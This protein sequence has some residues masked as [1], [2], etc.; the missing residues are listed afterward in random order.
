M[1]MNHLRLKVKQRTEDK[2][3]KNIRNLFKLKKMKQLKIEY[4]EILGTVLSMKKKIITNQ[5]E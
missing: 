1:V 3:I 2:I 5:L 4:L